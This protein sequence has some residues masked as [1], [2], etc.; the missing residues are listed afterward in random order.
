MPNADGIDNCGKPN[1]VTINQ[2]Q[3]TQNTYPFQIGDI[4]HA[5]ITP[6]IFKKVFICMSA[7]KT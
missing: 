3:R 1:C 4:I 2:L 6:T 5:I 7:A